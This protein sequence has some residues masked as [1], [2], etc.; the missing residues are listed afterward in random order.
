MTTV[1][2]P[3]A[4][5]DLGTIEQDLQ[6]NGGRNRQLVIGHGIFPIAEISRASAFA[7]EV[8]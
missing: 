2:A 6:E 3:L 5:E 4:E 1:E 8:T 7:E